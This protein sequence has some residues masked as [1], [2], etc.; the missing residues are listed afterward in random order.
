MMRSSFSYR[1]RFPW[2]GLLV[3]LVGA[4]FVDSAIAEPPDPPIQCIL[5]RNGNVLE[6]KPVEEGDSITIS[7]GEHHSLRLPSNQVLCWAADRRQLYQY[8]LEHRTKSDLLTHLDTARWCI[9]QNLLEPASAELDAAEAI[10]AEHPHVSQVQAM[11]RTTRQQAQEKADTTPQP[12]EAEQR[13]ES[14][15]KKDQT[16]VERPTDSAAALARLSASSIAD[17]AARVQPIL[18]NRCGQAGCHGGRDTPQ[19]AWRLALS[20]SPQY[21]RLSA[22]MTRGNL[23]GLVEWIDKNDPR[24]SPVLRKASEPHAGM[25]DAPLGPADDDVLAELESWTASVAGELH[26]DE[27]RG[28]TRTA[29]FRPKSQDPPLGPQREMIRDGEPLPDA[30]G[31]TSNGSPRPKRLPPVTNPFDPR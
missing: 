9:R 26:N 28:A 25:L 21:R 13:P 10:D 18:I 3:L 22:E 29:T 12:P 11:L 16:K 27:P 20:P 17:Y 15:S 2:P 8:R 14:E 4:A 23:R 7:M 31:V 19:T 6:G 5:L 1:I 24:L 30:I